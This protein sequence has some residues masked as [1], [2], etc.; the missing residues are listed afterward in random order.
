MGWKLALLVLLKVGSVRWGK[1]K[2]ANVRLAKR[3]F[4]KCEGL[5]F[6]FFSVTCLNSKTRLA[7]LSVR[8]VDMFC[9]WIPFS[10]IVL[11]CLLSFKHWW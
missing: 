2:C 7:C 9:M 8:F 10:V 3:N 11:L 5:A 1:T 4:K 6:S